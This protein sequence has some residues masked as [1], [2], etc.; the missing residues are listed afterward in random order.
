MKTLTWNILFTIFWITT[1]GQA[2]HPGGI[3]G[4]KVWLQVASENQSTSQVVNLISG[5]PLIEGQLFM[6]NHNPGIKWMENTDLQ[7][8]LTQFRGSHLTVFTVYQLTSIKEECIYSFDSKKA[9]QL[10]LTSHRFAD[11]NEVKYMN[12]PQVNTRTPQINTY[13][14]SQRNY[15]GANI[16][17]VMSIGQKPVFQNIPVDDFSGVFFEMII[18]DRT[19]SPKEKHQ[20]E[21]YLAIKYGLTLKNAIGPYTNLQGQ[22]LWPFLDYPEMQTNITIIGNDDN[23]NFKQ[24]SSTSTELGG[25]LNLALTSPEEVPEW[26]YISMRSNGKYLSLDHK[27]TDRV[28]Q[29]GREWVIHPFGQQAETDLSWEDGD[30][31]L[32]QDSHFWLKVYRKGSDNPDLQ[33]IDFYLAKKREGRFYI[34]GLQW[35]KEGSGSDCFTILEGPE[36]FVAVDDSQTSCKEDSNTLPFK[37]VGGIPPY[38]I[39]IF[40][41]GQIFSS[42]NIDHN[43]VTEITGVYPGQWSIEVTDGHGMSYESSFY[44]QGFLPEKV[45][46]PS[47]VYIK[48]G[49]KILLNAQSQGSEYQ[50]QWYYSNNMISSSTSVEI[51][52]PG[53]YL[54]EVE[55]LGCKYWKKF[56]VKVID[57]HL[58]E[59]VTVFPNPAPGGYFQTEVQLKKESPLRMSIVDI[60]GKQIRDR[61]LPA[62]TFHFAHEYIPV[63]G[64][65]LISFRTEDEVITR[66][67]VVK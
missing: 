58:F 5:E 59:K 2:V 56:N 26:A 37:V 60:N 4:V 30:L 66:K 19:L 47:T 52:H 16:P 8:P 24:G 29:M 57:S 67:V 18:Y 48:D 20:V 39:R 45:D 21:S 36:L 12:F 14:H 49:E 38:S 11:L 43:Q 31:Q 42:Q 25:F 55:D 50:Y 33:F 10:L 62:S 17:E 32:N 53:S 61:Y 41:E 6:A 54:L 63:S 1:N 65:Y 51:N 23:Q 27:V 64:I 9:H 44:Q 34:E 40:S 28:Y 22:E 3:A 7:V 46:I 35:D 15:R 13:I